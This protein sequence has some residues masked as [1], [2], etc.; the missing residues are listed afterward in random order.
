MFTK[1]QLDKPKLYYAAI[2]INNLHIYINETI[3][4]NER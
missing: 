1:R 4:R 2:P 3:Y